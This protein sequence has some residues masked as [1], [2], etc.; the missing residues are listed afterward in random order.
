MPFDLNG[1]RGELRAGGRWVATLS[2]ILCH[3]SPA[4]AMSAS[5]VIEKRDDYWL[6]HGS[7]YA[8]VLIVGK[9]LWQWRDV[10]ITVDGDR[11]TVAGQGRPD[12][13]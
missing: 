5:G 12:I 10:T 4:D 1:T 6:A 3:V 7:R 11:V 9:R 8:L 13:R 2:N